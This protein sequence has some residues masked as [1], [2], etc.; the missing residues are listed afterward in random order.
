MRITT[1]LRPHWKALTLALL[2]V[3]G[4]T[5]AD[6]LQPWPIKV[7]IDNVVQSKKLPGWL[8]AFVAG[9]F[10]GGKYATLNF[11]VATPAIIAVIGAVSGYMQKYLTTRGSQWVGHDLRRIVYHHIQRLSP[12]RPNQTRAGGPVI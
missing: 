1:L 6:V 10:A 4:E 8:D 5:F 3:V 7:V 2:A 12:A 9:G 11:A